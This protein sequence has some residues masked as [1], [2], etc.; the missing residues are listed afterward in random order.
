MQFSDGCYYHVSSLGKRKWTRLHPDLSRARIMWA[1]IEGGG[2][3]NTGLFTTALDEYLVSG[4]FLSLSTNTKK[5][6][7]LIAVQLRE[8]FKGAPL[9]LVT[10]AH[11]AIWMDKCES[12]IRANT[13]KAIVSNVFEVAVRH[14]IVNSNPAKQ[15]GFNVIPARD[16]ILNDGEYRSIYDNAP[17]HVQVAMDIGYLTGSR[18]QDILDIKLQDISDE[19]IYIKQGKTKKKMLFVPSAALDEA[20]GRAKTLPRPIRGMHLLCNH[21]GRPYP[22]ATFNRHWIEAYRAAKVVDVHFHDIRAKAAM[23]AKQ[24][25]LDYQALLGHTTRAMSDKYIKTKSVQKV[26]SL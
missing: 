26:A 9:A 19:G 18:I 4:K 24:M 1:Q 22:Y 11:I 5:Q 12:K 6:Y 16:R 17:A 21:S 2:S 13:G 8:F 23:D 25:G 7:E 15:I 10:P 3:L 14:G 20:I